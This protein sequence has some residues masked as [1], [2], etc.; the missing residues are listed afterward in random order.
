MTERDPPAHLAEQR[1]E[2]ADKAINQRA[3]S[4][5]SSLPLGQE[6]D[7]LPI[8]TYSKPFI[9]ERHHVLC[10][11]IIVETDEISFLNAKWDN[12]ESIHL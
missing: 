9:E 1:D 2:L 11:I 4:W 7:T 8:S 5:P 3:R 12:N 10:Q 6:R